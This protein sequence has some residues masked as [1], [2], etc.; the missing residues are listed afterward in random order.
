MGAVEGWL[1]NICAIVVTYHPDILTLDK[2]VEA[3]RSQVE[4]ILIVNNGYPDD[5]IQWFDQRK[6]KENIYVLNLEKN[7]GVAAGHNRGIQWAID[8]NFKYVI[9]LDQDSIPMPQMVSKLM[10]AYEELRNKN[11]LVSAVGPR[12][13]DSRTG[14]MSHFVRYGFLKYRI[15]QR[16]NYG[17]VSVDFLYSSG[18]LISV[19]SLES[20]G[21]MDE[22]LFIDHVDTEWFL[23]ARGKGYKAF[24]VCDA[25]MQHSLGDD[26]IPVWFVRW[27][28]IP[29]HSPLRHYYTFRNS[30][31]IYKRKYARLSWILNDML[32]NFMIFCFFVIFSNSRSKH[33]IFMILG[34]IHGVKGFSGNLFGNYS[35][36]Q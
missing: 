36:D 8:N 31:L 33:A 1:R 6:E 14:K 4:N 27:W 12:C 7:L 32:R 30:I 34:V 26:T 2:L 25:L 28:N 19:E 3:T 35:A 18:S 24:G 17:V 21:Y 9:L 5:V 16:N 20:I 22:Q 13:Q 10:T 23:R 11:L 15:P 29:K